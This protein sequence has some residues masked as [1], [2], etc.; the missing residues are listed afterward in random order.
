MVSVSNIILQDANIFFLDKSRSDLLIS[1]AGEKPVLAFSLSDIPSTFPS[2][3]K[4][5]KK[6]MDPYMGFK[7]A[8][9]NSR[10]CQYITCEALFR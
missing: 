3:Q 2:G 10:V 9:C 7:V 1:L 8:K 4:K 6:E 5:K